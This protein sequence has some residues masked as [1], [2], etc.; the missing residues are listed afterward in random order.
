MPIESILRHVHKHPGFVYERV[1]WGGRT[2]ELL[3]VHVRP[4]TGSR[5]ICSKCDTKGPG[6]DRLPE[7]SFT[8]IPLWGIAV[9]LIYAMRRVDCPTCGVTVEKVP[10]ANGK[11]H[12]TLVYAWFL[13]SWAKVLSWQEVAR[14]FRTSWDTV[15][16]SVEAAVVWGLAQRC[17]DGIRSI[18][19]DELAWKKGY[20]YLTLVYQLATTAANGCSGS[21]RTVP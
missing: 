8:F 1:E 4:R 5:A 3:H 17:L 20:K 10:W 9:F 11:E 14:R 12:T 6:Y 21:A 16:R 18:G 13:A 15:F 19:V 2:G 7:R